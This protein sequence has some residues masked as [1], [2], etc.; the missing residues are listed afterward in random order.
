MRGYEGDQRIRLKV[1]EEN[2][3]AVTD[4]I[5][6]R[7]ISETLLRIPAVFTPNGDGVNDTWVLA[8]DP[9]V[10]FPSSIPEVLEVRIYDRTGSLVWYSNNGYE[11]W[12]GIDMYGRVLPV[13]S[14]HYE[15]IYIEDGTQKTARGAVTIVR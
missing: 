15:I 11:P 7:A 10:R 1:T 12:D 8:L 2:G 14:Y 4:S 3:C 13:D 9:N 6:I 5:Q